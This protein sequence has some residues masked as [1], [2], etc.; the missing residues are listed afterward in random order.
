[1]NGK[2]GAVVLNAANVEAVAAVTAEYEPTGAGETVFANATAGAFAIPLPAPGT[3]NKGWRFT[4]VNTSTNANAVT[5]EPKAG[6]I[7]GPEDGVTPTKKLKLGKGQVYY[8]ITVMSDGSNY[9]VI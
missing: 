3:G 4:V 6:E 9:H 5:V 1:V 8:A 7:L 2:T